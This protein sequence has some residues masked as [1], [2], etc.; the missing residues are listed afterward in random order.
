MNTKRGRSIGRIPLLVAAL[1]LPLLAWPAFLVADT[2]SPT[3]AEG[4]ADPVFDIA[5]EEYKAGAYENAITLY[6]GLLSGPAL[7]AADIHYNIGNASFKLN[8]YGK[9]IASYRRA[10][11]LA[12]RDQD[13]VANLRFV[14][15]STVDKLDQP[16][17]TELLREVFF[18][19]Y[20]LSA[21][22]TET[23]F[24]CAYLAA[25][26]FAGTHIFFKRRFL[27]ILALLALLPAV[28]FGASSALRWYGAASPN[29]AV[30]VVKEADVHTGPGQ[31]YVV[32]VSLHDGAE[33][34]VRK[35]EDGW[36]QIELSDGRRGW[37]EESQIE[38]I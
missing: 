34:V 37:I 8:N 6:H 9:A 23:I 2:D 13:I 5:N 16:K 30:I 20:G 26:V 36:R 22:E 21:S 27:H 14:R 10:R 11:R 17:S 25:A 4:Q 1:L 29:Q 35:S 12:P 28:V 33:L 18:F 31:N 19:H 3:V 32:S 24:L 15:E 38:I 7:D